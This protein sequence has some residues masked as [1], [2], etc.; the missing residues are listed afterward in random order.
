MKPKK[1]I[2]FDFLVSSIVKA[3]SE[4]S[5]QAA[6]AVN[7]SLTLRNWLIGFYIAEY[8]LYGTD[9]AQYGQKLLVLLAEQLQQSS[10]SNVARQQLYRY[11]RFYQVYPQLVLFGAEQIVG[12]VYPQLNSSSNL[13]LQRLSYGHFERLIQANSEQQRIF[14]EQQC[15]YGQWSVRELKRQ[16]GSFLFERTNTTVS[17]PKAPFDL[18]AAGNKIEI[19]DPYIFEFLGIKP[20][21]SATETTI[22]HGLISKIGD[23][24]L[25][26]G[27]GF[28]FEARQ[29]RILIG[30]EHFFVDLVFYHRILKC[31]VLIELKVGDFTHEHIGQLNTYVTWFKRHMMSEGDNPPIGVLLCNQKNQ[32]LVEY[33]LA[34]LDNDLFVSKYL[35]ELPSK[36]VIQ[37]FL[38]ETLKEHL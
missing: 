22:E 6:R 3:D 36:E 15:M 12:T 24:I 28:C 5:L 33:A 29:K 18:S 8:E 7:I 2:S 26:L 10:L 16:M 14:Y 30:T 38:E 9:R 27:H 37:R 23:F 35:L 19:R 11:I 21:E 25:E 34:G 13:L 17:S 1:A 31:H 20:S 32:A 4:L